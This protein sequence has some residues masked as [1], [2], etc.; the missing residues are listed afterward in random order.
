MSHLVDHIKS[1]VLRGQMRRVNYQPR[2]TRR[3]AAPESVCPVAA[4][5]DDI[6]YVFP[7]LAPRSPR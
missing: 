5:L 7:D 6:H 4:R 1:A 3:N 2:D